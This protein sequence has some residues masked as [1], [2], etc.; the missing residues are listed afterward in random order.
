MTGSRS[1][2]PSSR[3]TDSGKSSGAGD[4]RSSAGRPLIPSMRDAMRNLSAALEEP[5]K[6]INR[7]MTSLSDHLTRELG[8]RILG[9]PPGEF[10]TRRRRPRVAL[11]YVRAACPPGGYLSL[12]GELGMPFGSWYLTDDY[13][14]REGQV[15]LINARL[16]WREEL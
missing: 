1:P 15:R 8:A 11:D 3:E 14:W 9:I 16:E 4:V 5:M 2:V 13:T 6:E 12:P 7:S 10:L